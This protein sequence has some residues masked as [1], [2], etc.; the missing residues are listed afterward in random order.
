I[1]TATG[2]VRWIL[3]PSGVCGPDCAD[4]ALA[5][6][7]TAGEAFPTGVRHPPIDPA[8]GCFLVIDLG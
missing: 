6:A 8:C 3:D 4:N 5:G 2:P 1:A 7:I